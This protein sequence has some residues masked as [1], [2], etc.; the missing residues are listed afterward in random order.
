MDRLW[1]QFAALGTG[2]RSNVFFKARLKLTALY[3]LVVAVIIFGFSIFLYQSISRNLKDASDD[4]FADTG[5]HQHFVENTLGSVEEEILLADLVILLASAGI[6]YVLAGYT[7]RPIQSALEA[8]KTFSENASH[9]LRTP[10]AVMKNDIEVLLRN[11]SPTSDAIQATLK[12]NLEEIDRMTKMGKDLLVL[13]RSERRIE[14]D[15]EKIDVAMVVQKITDKISPLAAAKNISI[16]T[17]LDTPLFIMGNRSALEHILLNLLQNAMQYTPQGGS[18]QAQLTSI[19]SQVV[20]TI[21]DTGSGIDPKDLP[22][23]FERFYKGESASGTG[24]GLSIVKELVDQHKGTIG[25]ESVR[26][27]GTIA[28]VHFPLTA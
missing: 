21:S 19:K 5:S 2:S 17:T 22:H 14:T 11:P 24:L 18:V 1:K 15:I 20:V 27:Q 10:L 8:Q 25:V 3:V 16:T 28:T 4:D 23:I 12:S 6:S 9:E 13:A 7:L 26:G